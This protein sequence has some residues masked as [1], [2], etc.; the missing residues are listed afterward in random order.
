MA[1]RTKGTPVGPAA[2]LKEERLRVFCVCELWELTAR[3]MNLHNMLLQAHGL[4]P[5]APMWEYCPHC[6][7]K[8]LKKTAKAAPPK[9]VLPDGSKLV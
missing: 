9:L 6:G 1:K 4:P 7:S 5:K 3:D 8:L 2:K